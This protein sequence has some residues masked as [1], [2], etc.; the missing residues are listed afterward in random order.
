VGRACSTNRGKRNACRILMR[1]PKGK[2]ALG[3]P[4]RMWVDINNMHLREIGW[5]GNRLD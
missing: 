2:R 5:C 1:K 3:R 4:R